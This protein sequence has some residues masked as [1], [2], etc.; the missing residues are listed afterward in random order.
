LK[1]TKETTTEDDRKLCLALEQI[2]KCAVKE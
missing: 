2:Q 1:H